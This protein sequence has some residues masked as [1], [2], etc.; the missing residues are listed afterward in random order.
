[1][2][3]ACELGFLDMLEALSPQERERIVRE[4]A[5]RFACDAPQARGPAAKPAEDEHQP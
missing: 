5:T 3:I 4:E 1:M 2:C